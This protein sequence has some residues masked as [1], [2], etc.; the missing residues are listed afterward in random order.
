MTSSDGRDL[1]SDPSHRSPDQL[2]L[3][4]ALVGDASDRDAFRRIFTAMAPKLKAFL[5]NTGQSPQ[6]AEEILQDTMLKVWRKAAL[7]DRSKSAGSTWIYSIAKN[8]R[9]DRIRKETKPAPDPDDPSF[10][11]DPPETGEQSL[12]RRQDQNR[13]QL[14]MSVLPSEQIKIINMSFFEDKSHAEIS[15]ELN[16]PLGTVKSRI[17]LAFGKIRAE[18]ERNQ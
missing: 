9:I 7:F 10:V 3:D 18:L 6:E 5:I 16:L 13:I 1:S 4:L 11:Q 2:N 8:A 15:E 12:N 14:A 17:R